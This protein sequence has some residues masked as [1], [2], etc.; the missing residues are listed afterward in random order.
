VVG[1]LGSGRK[2]LAV[3]L[4]RELAGRG[5]G[6]YFIDA[7]ARPAD[8]HRAF[9]LEVAPESLMGFFAEKGIGPGVR[10]IPYGDQE[11]RA[12]LPVRLEDLPERFLGRTAEGIVFL[13][14]E[15]A[16]SR[17]PLDEPAPGW[18][19]QDIRIEGDRNLP[20]TIFKLEASRQAP[21]PDLLASLDWLLVVVDPTFS[22]VELVADMGERVVQLQKEA[23][24][25]TWAPEPIPGGDPRG[26]TLGPGHHTGLLAVLNHIPDPETEQ[27]FV[28]AIS[29]QAHI[30]PVGAIRED[31][32]IREAG[33]SGQPVPEHKAEARVKTIVD[34]IE[35]SERQALEAGMA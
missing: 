8:S 7:D 15:K 9:G 2:T 26:S 19:P 30:Q 25:G 33:L 12:P 31:W 22:S 10:K 29:Q 1:R 20:V 24:A 18:A 11:L 28:T 17:E 4:A 32:E 27:F 16:G 21:P 6:V 5:Y 3:L 13:S 14:L 23:P 34:R 35:E